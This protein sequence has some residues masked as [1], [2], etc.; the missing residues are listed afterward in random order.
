MKNYQTQQIR[1]ISLV[2]N[3]GAGKTTLAESMLEIGGV[4]TR[5][6]DIAS[7]NTVSD[8][9]LIEQENGNSL[10]STVMYSELGNTKFNILDC[11]GMDDFI[12]GVVSSLFATDIA[13]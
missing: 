1:N 7:K 5:K 12:G 4:I 6:G 8:Y 11:P 13:L 2:G 3:S 10:Y 9:R